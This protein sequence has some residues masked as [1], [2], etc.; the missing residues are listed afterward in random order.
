MQSNLS[1]KIMRKLTK[2]SS[3]KLSSLYALSCT[4]SEHL[5]TC[6]INIKR[7]LQFRIRKHLYAVYHGTGKS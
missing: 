3:K 1:M 7:M 5:P 2:E 6:Y 4:F